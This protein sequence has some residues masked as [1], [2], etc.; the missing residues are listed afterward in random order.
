MKITKENLI[1]LI[2]AKIVK[3]RKM[4]DYCASTGKTD[5]AEYYKFKRWN[6]EDIL[7]IVS[8]PLKF[9][10]E[11]NDHFEELMEIEKDGK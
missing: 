8:N 3:A 4:Q 7:D 5:R 1:R 2:S 9:N 11:W 10:E 6:Y